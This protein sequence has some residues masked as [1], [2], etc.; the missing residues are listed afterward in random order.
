M[1]ATDIC[2]WR[3]FE[4]VADRTQSSKCGVRSSTAAIFSLPGCRQARSIEQKVGTLSCI[5]PMW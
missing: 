3:A 5:D 4:S 1:A 2:S